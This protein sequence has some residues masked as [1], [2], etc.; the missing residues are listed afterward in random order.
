MIASRSSSSSSDSSSPSSSATTSSSP[1][2]LYSPSATSSPSESSS[3]DSS[4]VSSSSVISSPSVTSSF[5]DTL[6]FS[7]SSGSKPTSAVSTSVSGFPC[8]SPESLLAESDGCL[9]SPS[10]ISEE[11]AVGASLPSEY[12]SFTYSSDSESSISC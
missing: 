8:A 1:S 4:T 10:P 11:S 5:S 2:S 12:S 3:V 9:F 7:T 6:A